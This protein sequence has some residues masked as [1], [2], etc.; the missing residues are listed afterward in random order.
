MKTAQQKQPEPMVNQSNFDEPPMTKDEQKGGSD[1]PSPAP[2]LSAN[3]EPSETAR[4]PAFG[5]IREEIVSGGSVTTL[6]PNNGP[7]KSAAANSN[8]SPK[9][10]NNGRKSRYDEEVEDQNVPNSK[11]AGL[12]EFTEQAPGSKRSQ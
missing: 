11:A 6:T 9:E 1:L 2:E 12:T 8:K 3:Q 5:E 7:F 4:V 10:S